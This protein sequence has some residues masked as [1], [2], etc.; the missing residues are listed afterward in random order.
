MLNFYLNSDVPYK[1]LLLFC[2][3]V[4]EEKEEEIE[5]E[6]EEEEEEAEWNFRNDG[7]RQSERE[8]EENSIG[9]CSHY[10]RFYNKQHTLK[11]SRRTRST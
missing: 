9:Y 11:Y 1:R 2:F 6:E 3:V 5:E 7:D 4:K 10:V 8:R